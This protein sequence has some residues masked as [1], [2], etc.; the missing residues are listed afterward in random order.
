MATNIDQGSDGIRAAGGLVWRDGPEGR[1]LAVVR[2]NRY[3]GDW[4][5]PKGKLADGE[6]WQDAARREVR[7]ETGC[8]V[9]LGSFAGCMAYT[10]DDRPKV[11][12]FWNMSVIG[13]PEKPSDSEVEEVAWLAPE[14]ARQRLQYPLERALLEG[15]ESLPTQ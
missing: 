6:S 14:Q 1:V 10:V 9:H 12:T 3:D 2:R 13:D 8:Q 7:E 15:V 4:T 11:V 5:L